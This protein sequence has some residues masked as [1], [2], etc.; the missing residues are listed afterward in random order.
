GVGG[1]GGSKGVG[2]AAGGRH[3]RFPALGT[4]SGDWGGGGDVG[5]AAVFAAARSEDGRGPRTILEQAVPKH[6]GLRTPTELAEA[7]HRG[8]IDL[9]AEMISGERAARSAA[10]PAPNGPRSPPTDR[11]PPG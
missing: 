1:G 2:V 7:V 11:A 4:V 6:F 8:Q 9:A 3:A 10:G 5:L